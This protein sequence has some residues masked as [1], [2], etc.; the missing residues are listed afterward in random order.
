MP[1][2]DPLV[3]RL[4][5]AGCVF[6]E[7]EAAVLRSSARDEA[8]LDAFVIE[9]E[10]G[11][12][13]EH[14]VGWAEFCGLRVIVEPGVFVPRPRTERLVDRGLG[15]V[16]PG[17]VVVDA[18]CGSGAVGLALAVR[19]PGIRLVATDI[20]DHAAAVARRNLDGLGEV[21]VGDALDALP[22]ELLGR[23]VLITVIAPYVPTG[24]IPLLPHEARD[25]E[26][27][28]AL[29]GGPDGL[30]VLA[31]AIADSPRWLAPGGVL[32]TEVSEEQA[33]AAAGLLVAAGL[34]AEI[35][36]DEDSGSTLVLGRG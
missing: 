20:D 31:R 23:V 5:A 24:D 22:L 17:D 10:A 2:L 21:V 11:V 25:F 16:G 30:D 3:A 7:D 6:A 27:L 15:L 18:C 12:P 19:E 14:V 8:Q 28:L 36:S 32:L 33:P 1:D 4:R 34:A 35:E 13:L 26:P 29:D 9:R